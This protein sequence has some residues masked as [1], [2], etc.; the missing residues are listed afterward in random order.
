MAELDSRPGPWLRLSGFGGALAVLTCPVSVSLSQA[1]LMLALLGWALDSALA[2]RARRPPALRIEWRPALLAALLVFGFE[3][4]ALIVNA[5]LAASPG[6]RLLR[7]LRGEFKDVVL[8]PAAFWAMAWARDPGRR[9]RL[10]RWFETALWILVI[11]GLA[12]I[13]SIY[14]LAKIP[15]MMMSGWEVGPQARLQHHLGTL[16]VGER[17]IHFFMPIGLMNTHLTYAA[18]IMLAFPFLALGVL[19]NVILSPRDLLRGIGLS[20]TVLFGLASIVLVLNNGRS[21]IFG[22]IVATL[23]GLVYFIKTEIRWKALRLVP[24]FLLA[25]LLLFAVDRASSSMHYRFARVMNALLGESKHTDN[26]RPLVYEGSLQ[27]FAR[28]PVVGI[29]PGE[30]GPAIDHWVIEKG[31]EHPRL[32]VPFSLAQRGHAHNDLLHIL[33]I[34][35]PGGALAF[36]LFAWLVFAAVFRPSRDSRVQYWKWGLIALFFAGL[37]QCY[38]QDDETMLPFWLYLGLV[39]GSEADDEQ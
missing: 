23:C 24:L 27:L 21:A 7:G 25:L 28:N 9:E 31:A 13:F 17:P 26:Q 2:V 4:L 14:R 15:A 16:F 38:F 37:A 33:V 3:L 5:T 22:A 35:G 39:L 20:R 12:S 34:S 36:L 29:G 30:F 19:R 8:L 1:G 32:W 10:L 11:S 6:E 18:L